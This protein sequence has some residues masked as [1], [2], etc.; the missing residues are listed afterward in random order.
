MFSDYY[1]FEP[2]TVLSGGGKTAYK[3]YTPFYNAVIHKKV[4]HP[5]TKHIKNFARAQVHDQISLKEA[6]D[7]FTAPNQEIL[8]NGGRTI[9]IQRLKT[10]FR[11]Q[12]LYDSHRDFL[13]KIRRFYQRILSLDVSRCVRHIA[14]FL[15]LVL[16]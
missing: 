12:K 5:S 10:T 7:T 8:V 1:L 15:I 4:D 9:G 16:G 6:L 14:Y 13:L 2:G 11:E 3:K